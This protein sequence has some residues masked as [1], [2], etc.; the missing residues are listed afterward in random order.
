MNLFDNIFNQF[1]GQAQSQVPSF[2]TPQAPRTTSYVAPNIPIAPTPKISQWVRNGGFAPWYEWTVDETQSPIFKTVQWAANLFTGIQKRLWETAQEDKTRFEQDIKKKQQSFVSEMLAE[3]YS[4]DSIFK[5]LDQLKAKWEFDFKPWISESI[6][7]WAWERMKT[8]WETTERLSQIQDPLSRTVAG[9]VPYAGQT[10]A[11]VTQPIASAL[12]PYVSP[13]VKAIVEKTGQTQNIQDLSNQ[14]S[15]FEKTNPILAENIAGAL[16]VAQLAPV[17]FAKPIGNAIDQWVKTGAKAIVKWAEVVAPRVVQW[18]KNIIA[19][20]PQFIWKWL[21]SGAEYTTSLATGISKQA[22]QTIKK[23]PEL[24]KQARLWDITAEWE[25][26]NFARATEA[27]LTDLSELG[28]WYDSIKKWWIVSNSDEVWNIFLNRTKDVPTT[29]LTKA[30]KIVLKDASDYM[31]QLKWD[32]TDGDILAL[33][34]QLDSISYDPNTWMK[35]KLSPQWS[36]L[37]EGMRADI[38]SL[39]KEKIPW[40]KELDTKYAPEVRLLKEI[41]GNIYDANGNLKNNALSTI[42]N[43]VWKNKDLKLSKFEEIY[44][45][46]WARLRALKAYEEVSGLWEIKT[47]SIIRQWGAIAT[48]TAL[49]P[50]VWT[51]V[52]WIATNPNIV[53]RLLEAYWLATSKAKSIA[54]KWAKIT[55]S[56]VA[57]VKD[58]VK[59]V[60]KSEVEDI[61]TNIKFNPKT[62]NKNSKTLIKKPVESKSI[63]KP[64]KITK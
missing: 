21:E 63:V 61:I 5:A 50:W 28:K 38:D 33:R 49:L 32:L 47:G 56:E 58:A 36:R 62:E 29:Q 12:E 11:S 7:W 25:L 45:D 15:Q 3:W 48:W 19:K 54:S 34:K 55:P 30:D 22:Q 13:V 53:A 44:P 31:S 51:L 14:W 4:E 16:N 27:R 42:S 26:G 24:Y 35:R 37:V 40:L 18:S 59:K 1:T 23:T 9:I 46:L 64:K 6:V 10:V 41:K 17:P 39:A 52:W 2:A 43:I 8:I 60:P 57:I 20:T